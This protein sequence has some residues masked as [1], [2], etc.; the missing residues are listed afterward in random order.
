MKYSD[1]QRVQKIC[2]Y[3]EKLLAYINQNH[4]TKENGIVKTFEERNDTLVVPYI[5]CG[6]N[7]RLF[8]MFLIDFGINVLRNNRIFFFKINKTNFGLPK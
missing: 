5:F 3:A 8:R 6:N 2:E 7:Q 1:K 4:I